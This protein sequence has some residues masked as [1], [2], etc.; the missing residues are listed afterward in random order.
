MLK[1]HDTLHSRSGLLYTTSLVVSDL[2]TSDNQ[3]D[4][5]WQCTEWT[6]KHRDPK[7][8]MQTSI[9]KIAFNI[10]LF[11]INKILIEKPNMFHWHRQFISGQLSCSFKLFTHFFGG[12][13]RFSKPKPPPRHK[14]P[15]AW[16]F[17]KLGSKRF[18]SS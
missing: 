3:N 2:A 9:L 12:K 7:L 15:P 16:L 17:K 13:V 18:S 5:R 1:N 6:W 14:N 11:V 4:S 10:L 8:G